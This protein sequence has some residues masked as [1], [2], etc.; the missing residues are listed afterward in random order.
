[1]DGFEGAGELPLAAM[2]GMAETNKT[3]LYSRI[4]IHQETLCR[5]RGEI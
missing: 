2:K 1:M 3:I 4:E 5:I